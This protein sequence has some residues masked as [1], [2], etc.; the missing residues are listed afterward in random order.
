MKG[1]FGGFPATASQ[2]RLPHPS[3]T[4]R[5]R[6]WRSA[7]LRLT[8]FCAPAVVARRRR[9]CRLVSNV[10][11]CP[12]GTRP[13]RGRGPRPSGTSDGR[14][15]RT[16]ARGGPQSAAR[17]MKRYGD[18]SASRWALR[19]CRAAFHWQCHGEPA[20]SPVTPRVRRLMAASATG[21]A[22]AVRVQDGAAAGGTLLPAAAGP[23]RASH[24]PR[25]KIILASFKSF[26]NSQLLG[27]R[28]F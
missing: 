26:G 19:V 20:A 9:S 22:A 5:G 21:T 14:P 10:E 3:A 6:P 1:G 28:L 13:G 11:Y 27:R 12:I 15:N 25:I 23:R 4:A 7:D 16:R 8:A 18:G 2:G 17:V 24:R